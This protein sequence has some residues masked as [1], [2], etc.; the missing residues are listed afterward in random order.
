VLN[1][2]GRDAVAQS[3]A[4]CQA[5][6]VGKLWAGHTVGVK[7]FRGVGIAAVEPKGVHRALCARDALI[8][9]LVGNVATAEKMFLW[10]RR[11]HAFE[12]G[13]RG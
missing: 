4:S 2:Q 8:V 1:P 9:V 10:A 3:S 6:R 12:A 5:P 13:G 11:D 7:V